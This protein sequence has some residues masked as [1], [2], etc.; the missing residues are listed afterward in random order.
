M[1]L[2]KQFE[3]AQKLRNNGQIEDALILYSKVREIALEKKN[4]TLSTECSH[5][6]G[7]TYYQAE[8]FEEADKHLLDALKEFESRNDLEYAGFVLRDLGMSARSQ[9]KLNVAKDYFKKSIKNLHSTKNFG[10]EG[11]SHVKLGRLLADMGEFDE[12][13]KEINIGIKLLQNSKEKFFLSSAYLDRAKIDAKRSL[14]ILNSF[15]KKDEFIER[16]KVLDKI[17]ES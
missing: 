3:E 5:M 2:Q 4:L 1:N 13:Y 7:V 9:K 12:G 10:H 11:M 14:Q 6:I 8:N 17:I 16:R 15:A